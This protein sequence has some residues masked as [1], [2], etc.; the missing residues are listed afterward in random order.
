[1]Q[2]N[3]FTWAVLL[4]VFLCSLVYCITEYNLEVEKQT[5]QR[6]AIISDSYV[7]CLQ[8]TRTPLE[9]QVANKEVFRY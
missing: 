6:M 2:W 1:M 9:C 8:T 7:V 3:E 5:S 4:A